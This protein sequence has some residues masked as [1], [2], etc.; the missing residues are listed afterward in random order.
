MTVRTRFAPS[1]T[2]RLHAGNLRTALFNWLFARKN[3]GRFV[4]RIEDTDAARSTKSFE[5]AIMEDLEWAGLGWDIG[6]VRQSER[7]GVYME[8]AEKLVERGL[9]Y[10]CYCSKERLEDLKKTQT[11]KGLPPRYDGRCRGGKPSSA[12]K[13]N[14]AGVKPKGALPPVIRFLV[15]NEKCAFIDLVHGEMNFDAS[16]FGDFIIIDSD[17]G[18]AYNFAA[19]VDDADMR[20]THVIRGDDHLSNTPRQLVLFNALG[21]TPPQFAHIPLV[22]G[23]DKSPL[24]KRTTGASVEGLRKDGFLP[25]AVLNSC[26]RLGWSPKG[27]DRLLEL[28]ELIDDFDLE[29]LSKSPSVFDIGR[30]KGFNKEA[31]GITAA[32]GLARMLEVECPDA[33]L[34][35]KTIEAAK[36]SAATTAELRTLVLPII[37][38][39]EMSIE[40]AATMKER[41]SKAVL[42]AAVEAIDAMGGGT[43]DE[44][45]YK[46]IIDAVKKASGE[47]GKNLFH[48]LR[49]ALTGSF[50]GME[51]VKV[52]ALLGKEKITGRLKKY[53]T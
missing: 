51:L 9:A 48:P 46:T 50:E 35:E 53:L 14:G 4:L 31:I 22:L 24:S 13:D 3:A 18:A 17:G 15:P 27:G 43:L 41:H 25:L 11:A 10:R 44:T 26:A 32:A 52:F 20:I 38:E 28:S 37:G 23:P 33:A 36:H 42:K 16:A 5:L 39:P 29:R 30:L 19:T 40:A 47:K 49:A 34:L 8:A 7:L 6:P 21:F 2:G 45:A 1:P 12:I